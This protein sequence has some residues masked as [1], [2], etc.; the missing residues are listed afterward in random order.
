LGSPKGVRESPIIKQGVS[1]SPMGVVQKARHQEGG[2]CKPHGGSNN[3]TR[4]GEPCE[5]HYSRPLEVLGRVRRPSFQGEPLFKVSELLLC[6][7]IFVGISDDSSRHYPIQLDVRLSVHLLSLFNCCLY[8][9]S[10]IFS[11]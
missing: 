8:N 9:S 10:F 3:V 11:F 6:Y 7:K 5:T 2:K 1:V 4:R